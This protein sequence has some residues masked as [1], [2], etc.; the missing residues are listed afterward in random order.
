MTVNASEVYT[1]DNATEVELSCEMS[2]YLRPDE[3][4]QW[5][6]DGELIV[7]EN[8]YDITYTDGSR[9]RGQFGGIALGL[10]R[11]STLIISEPQQSDS[12]TYNCAIQGTNQSQNIK[13]IVEESNGKLNGYVI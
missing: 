10:T 6:K 11:V 5:F 4:L 7:T 8:R 12:A 2:L 3:D 9:N 1:F 13:L